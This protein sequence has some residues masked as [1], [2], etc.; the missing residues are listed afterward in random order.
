MS[1][2]DE[3]ILHNLSIFIYYASERRK[4]YL[5]RQVDC[6]ILRF[7]ILIYGL[8]RYI[9]INLIFVLYVVMGR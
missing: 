6:K 4:D 3:H 7:D 1:N 5:K 9:V 8:H 2:N